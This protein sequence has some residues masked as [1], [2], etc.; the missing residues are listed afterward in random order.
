MS[1]YDDIGAERVEKIVH[2]FYARSITD[3]MLAHFFMHID[4]DELVVQQI[5]FLSNLLGGPL[6]YQGKTLQDAHRP[7]SIRPPHFARRQILL[8]QTMDEMGLE[9]HLASAWLALEERLRS[10]IMNQTGGCQD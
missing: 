8:A 9:P 4:H 6:V 10:L 5:Q 2:A 1:L 3:P 7:F